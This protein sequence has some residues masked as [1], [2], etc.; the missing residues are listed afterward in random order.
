MCYLLDTVY[1]RPHPPNATA[2]PMLTNTRAPVS[3]RSFGRISGLGL[4][5]AA[6][7]TAVRRAAPVRA[8]ADEKSTVIQPLNG[9]PFIGMLETPITSTPAVA[10]FL[11]NLPAYRVAVSPLLR[12]TEVGLAHGF[13]LTGPF[14][15]L[16]PLRATEFAELAGCL[17]GAGVVLILSLC[18]TV[19]GMASF[20]LDTDG[21]TETKT[22]SGRAIAK[23]PLQSSEGFAQ[24][25]AGW[26]VGGLS[27]VIFSYILTQTLPYYS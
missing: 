18:L 15:K 11:S 23:D 4:R 9:D 10:Y 5:P 13:F 24:F 14:I 27:G 6:A 20:Q 21:V 16:G 8:A 19:Y 12:G 3:S 26:T 1:C 17:S 2:M 25:A 7:R 22:L